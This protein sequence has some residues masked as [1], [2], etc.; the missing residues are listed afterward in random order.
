[1]QNNPLLNDDSVPVDY[2]SVLLVHLNSAFDMRLNAHENAIRKLV[3]MARS[4]QPSWTNLVLAMDALDANLQ[5]LFYGVLP[6]ACKGTEWGAAMESGL[7]RTYERFHARPMNSDVSELYEALAGKA[8]DSGLDA[9]QRATLKRALVEFRM[10]GA[11]LNAEQKARLQMLNEQIMDLQMAFFGNVAASVEKLGIMIDEE[12]RLSGLPAWIR[13]EMAERAATAAQAQGKPAAGWLVPCE[14]QFYKTVLESANER[15]LREQVYSAYNAR[16]SRVEPGQDNGAVLEQLADLR[17]QHARTIGA[18][19][20]SQLFMQG[21]SA[22]SVE[23]VRALLLGLADRIR[24]AM[25]KAKVTIGQLGKKQGLDDVHPW[26]VDYLLSRGQAVPADRFREHFVLTDVIAAMLDLAQRLFGLTF[27]PVALP[28]WHPSVKT[29]E[30]RQDN[31]LIGYL[32]LDAV[33]Y[34]GKFASGPG[35]FYVRNR[36]NDAQGQFH[37]ATVIM[38]TD[39]PDGAGADQTLLDHLAL[40]K[41]F[42]E[43]G[44]VLHHL[45]TRT[46]NHLLSD[47]RRAGT[48]GTELYGKLLERWVWNAEFLASVSAHHVSRQPLAKAQVE[49]ALLVLRQKALQECAHELSLA[50]FDLELHTTPWDGKP[51]QQRL[52]EFRERCGCW[53]LAGFEKP[54]NALQHLVTGYAAGYYGYIWGEVNAIDMFSRFE[55]EG[56]YKRALGQQLQEALFDPGA[57]RRLSEGVEVFLGRAMTVDAFLNWYGVTEVE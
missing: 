38:C 12:Q 36:R 33:Q 4:Q 10:A 26:D 37:P 50:L 28:T 29:F 45:L 20:Y 49:S 9:H 22:D 57:S 51:V 56:L 42:H 21:Q 54:A 19:S 5:A 46:S 14:E 35:T 53:P 41:L 8:D 44:H 31:I 34:P 43:F 15:A 32:Y 3:A 39:N 13:L 30:V 1:M 16:G 17:M 40:R 11:Q 48:D 6:L 24:P 55:Q 47:P 25:Q 7:K 23:Q 52:L 18:G 2:D 27:T